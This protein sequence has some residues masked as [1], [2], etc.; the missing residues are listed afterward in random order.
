MLTMIMARKQ[1]KVGR[2]LRSSPRDGV[3]MSV[4]PPPLFQLTAAAQFLPSPAHPAPPDPKESHFTLIFTLVCYLWWQYSK[5]VS[6]VSRLQ[7]TVFP[8]NL[9]I[10]FC[11]Y[12][13]L[14]SEQR[15]AFIKIHLEM[16]DLKL[17]H[18]TSCGRKQNIAVPITLFQLESAQNASRRQI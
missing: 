17:S 9:R 15:D 6:S 11:K 13:T 1:S 10:A 8:K 5:R 14:N 12:S 3:R 2:K 4:P 7:S 18:Q 16:W